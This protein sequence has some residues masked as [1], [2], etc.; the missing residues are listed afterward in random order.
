[1]RLIL[2]K[3]GQNE[4]VNAIIMQAAKRLNKMGSKQWANRQQGESCDEIEAFIARGEIYFYVTEKDEIA[5]MIYACQRQLA[6]DKQLWGEEENECIHYLHRVAIADK[7]V[8]Q[9]LGPKM[10]AAML[11]LKKQENIA[12][13]LDCLAD[14]EKLNAFYQQAGFQFVRRVYQ[15]DTGS[16]IADFHLYQWAP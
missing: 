15:H 12:L 5:G 8:G 7:F 4:Q 11:A 6:W 3:P 1:M 10:I 13:R 16:Q 14:N 2:A 9:H